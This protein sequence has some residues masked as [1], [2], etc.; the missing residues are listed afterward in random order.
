MK[1]TK[2]LFIM[3][4]AGLLLASCNN[5]AKK[6]NEALKA[7]IAA[8]SAENNQLA[9]GTFSLALAVEEYHKTLKEIDQQMTAIDEKHQLVKQ[10]SVEI[11]NDED[12]KEDI[13]LHIEHI[14]HMMENSKQK[15]AHLNNNLNEL[16][17]EN[18]DQHE[19]IHQ[20]DIYIN[21]LVNLVV[22]RD[23]E[24]KALHGALMVQGVAIEGL[25]QAYTEQYIY[26]DVLLDIINTGFFVS[27]TKKELK[28]MGILDMEGGF[29]GIGRVKTLNANAPVQFL[30]PIDIRTTDIIE[31]T[32]KKAELITTHAPESYE[33]T[34]DKENDLALLGIANKLKFW[35]ETNYLVVEID[36]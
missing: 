17:K 34:F 8:L 12:V 2:I 31:L 5:Q 9:E 6:E 18:A 15:I 22:K 14:N 35:Q 33:F 3:A 32:G 26:N 16:R 30:T 29:I 1:H 24:I 11:K 28:E 10:Q 23:N 7:E 27:G 21:N 25:A 4:F 13:L 36:N 20:M 19:Q